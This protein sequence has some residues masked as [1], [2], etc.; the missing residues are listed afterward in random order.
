MANAP[1]SR[2]AVMLMKAGRCNANVFWWSLP[3]NPTPFNGN[4]QEVLDSSPEFEGAF[5]ERRYGCW[6]DLGTN[7]VTGEQDDEITVWRTLVQ[8]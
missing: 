7:V 2:N 4:P 6:A 3:E 5:A 8:G 1:F